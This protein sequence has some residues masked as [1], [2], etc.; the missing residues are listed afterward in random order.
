MRSRGSLAMTEFL[1]AEL[2]TLRQDLLMRCVANR[3]E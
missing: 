2:P 3:E 1:V